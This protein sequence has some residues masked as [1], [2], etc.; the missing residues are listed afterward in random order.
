MFAIDM[1]SRAPIYEQLYKRVAELVMQGALESDDKLP[2]VRMLAKELGVNP[3]TVQK[4]YQ[5]L[6]RDG[7]IY[8]QAGRGSFISPLDTSKEI[9]K[10]KIITEFR[11][12]VV[13]ALRVGLQKPELIMEI[14]RC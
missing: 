4:A 11:A 6:E 10:E 2:T 9:I 7:I 3:N 5:E 13:Q 1:Y 14:E 12:A 8:S